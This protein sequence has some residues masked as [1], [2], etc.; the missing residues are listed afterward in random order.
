MH[1]SRSLLLGWLVLAG[2]FAV[3][4][5]E[6]EAPK[7]QHSPAEEKAIAR[8]R[9]LGGLALE[10]AQNDP[11]LDVSYQQVDGKI[12]DE[13]MMLLKDLKDLISLNLR[14][15]DV[16][17]AQ[18]A[19][20]AG[21]T[22]LIR[23]HL[24]RTK[25]TDQGMPYLKGLINLEYLN[26]YGTDVGDPGLVNLEGMKKL[27]HLYLWQTKVT[28]AGVAKLQKTLPQVEITRGLDLLK[29]EEK[30]PE[31]KGKDDK[32]KAKEDKGKGKDDKAKSKDDKAK[33]KDDK[34]KS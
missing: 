23:L 29:V 19:P 33:A 9:Q 27:K 24:E 1:L 8:I 20:L 4:A 15:K 34:N 5:Q 22:S 21:I 31:P 18:L 6:K 30:K 10:V 17:D 12:T 32:A 11:R 14:G 25:I 13:H 7:A 26:L 3:L 2:S 16:T 28:D